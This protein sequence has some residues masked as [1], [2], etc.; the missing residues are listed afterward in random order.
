MSVRSPTL[1]TSHRI[2]LFILLTRE[3]SQAADFNFDETHIQYTYSV[4][5]INSA[6]SCGLPT[7]RCSGTKV[8]FAR[9]S[10]P[11]LLFLLLFGRRNYA[12]EGFKFCGDEITSI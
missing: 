2:S 7:H 10:K 6:P 3:P 9:L 11:A 5:V 12:M 1:Y 8:P 4:S